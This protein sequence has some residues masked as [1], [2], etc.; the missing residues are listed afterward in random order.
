MIDV[1]HFK[2]YNDHYGHQ[3]GDRCL[4]AVAQSIKRAIRTSDVVARYGGEEFAVIL[5]DTNLSEVVT[6]AERIL[7]AVR[8]LDMPHQGV[9]PAVSVSVSLG[10]ASVVPNDPRG[11]RHLIEMA[12]R[13]LYA[14]KAAGRD[15]TRIGTLTEAAT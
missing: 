8:A 13:G 1:D 3:Q 5:T 6:I 2:A 7:T 11:T 14:A 10:A 4:R 15:Q 9:E 12:D